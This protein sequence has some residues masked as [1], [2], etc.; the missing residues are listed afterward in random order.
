MRCLTVF[1]AGEEVSM[2][3]A[4][5]R[6]SPRESIEVVGDRYGLEVVLRSKDFSMSSSLSER[7][8]ESARFAH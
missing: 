3:H 7:C 2:S 4:I 8:I 5:N 6:E 1:V